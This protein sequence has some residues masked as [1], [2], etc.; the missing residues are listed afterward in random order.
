MNDI[1]ILV[2]DSRPPASLST[3]SF[4][5]ES[6]KNAG[7]ATFCC[8]SLINW[9]NADSLDDNTITTS[10]TNPEEEHRES[11]IHFKSLIS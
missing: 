1:E 4:S 8:V 11:N 9:T 7:A 6:T 3:F 5:L 2:Q 10:G